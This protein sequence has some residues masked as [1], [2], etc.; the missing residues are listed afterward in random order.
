MNL[1]V[2]LFEEKWPSEKHKFI[3]GIVKLGEKISCRFADQIITVSATCK[4][5]LI[6]RGVPETK[7]TLVLNSANDEVFKYNPREFYKLS[8]GVKLLYHGTMAYRFGIHYAIEAMKEINEKIPGSTFEVYGRYDSD[9]RKYLEKLVNDMNLKDIVKLNGFVFREN[10][11]EVI[12]NADIGIIPYP[13]TD[14]MHLALP[15]KAFE[16]ISSGLPVVITRLKDMSMIFPD[17]SITYVDSIDPKEIAK[18]VI[19]SS[20]NRKRENRK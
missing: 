5:R 20:L 16:Y 3:K 4:Q 19:E 15:T 17:N 18:A 12:Q 10:I 13:A 14:Y 1:T 8:N 9:Y 11:P 7:I 6:S 2:E